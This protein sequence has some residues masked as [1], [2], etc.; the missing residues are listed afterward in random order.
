VGAKQFF[1]DF[2]GG[3][4][5]PYH[6]TEKRGRFV[7][8]LWLGLK[9][10]HWL[11][12]TWGLLRQ[13][14]DLKGFFRFLRMEYST[15]EL[16]CLQNSYSRFVEICEYHGGAQRGGIRIPEGYRGKHWE[17]FVKELHS[18]FPGMAVTV[19]HQAGKSRNGKGRADLERR[20]IHAGP[21]SVV[22][23]YCNGKMESESRDTRNFKNQSAGSVIAD[24]PPAVMDPNAPCLTCK[25]NFKWA[26]VTRTLRIT[27]LVE[28]T[29]QAKWVSL[30]TKAIGLAQPSNRA[31][32]AQAL[33]IESVEEEQDNDSLCNPLE[34]SPTPKTWVD[35]VD[36]KEPGSTEEE[37]HADGE[38]S[39]SDEE[40]QADDGEF[41]L[42][43]TTTAILDNPM[44]D[45]F[46]EHGYAA[47]EMEEPSAVL[48]LALVQVDLAEDFQGIVPTIECGISMIHEESE[49]RLSVVDHHS[50]EVAQH[51]AELVSPL[52]CEPLAV[53][54]PTTI[55]DAPEKPHSTGSEW[56]NDQYRGLCELVGFPLD[57]HE[58]QCLALL[59]RIE[60]SRSRKKG[61]LGSWTVVCSGKKGARELRN[62]VSSVNYEGRQRGCC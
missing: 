34:P 1:F 22:S 57:S 9:S 16:S 46:V 59:R 58:K 20:V 42:E 38:L 53:V 12:A 8:S 25:C 44:G 15:L 36:V 49:S 6:I 37:T 40:T 61:E 55:L 17:R 27:K 3:R 28:G 62:L 56:V 19:E 10:L 7:G 5:A 24:L 52:V 11:I 18:F 48:D 30:K 23:G 41:I 50:D 26:P 47:V 39:S 2:D 14:E 45:M 60:A 35:H 13:T 54:V 29:R 21:T 31:I 43:N 32:Q 33:D 51:E 4:T